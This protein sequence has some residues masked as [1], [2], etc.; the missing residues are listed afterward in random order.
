MSGDKATLAVDCH[1]H[2]YQFADL[3]RLLAAAMTNGEKARGR[4]E[5]PA[6]AIGGKAILPTL[7]LTEPKGRDSFAQILDMAVR[8]ERH[9]LPGW[10]LRPGG[11][12][13]SV[14]AEGDDGAALIISGQQV[15][16][17]DCLEILAIGCQPDIEDG[18]AL[19]A[20]LAAIHKNGAFPVFPWGVG[21]WLGR[22]GRLIDALV[23]EAEPGDLAL[24]DTVA[25]PAWW[26]EPRFAAARARGLMI[27]RGSDPLPLPGQVEKAGAFGN[28]MR[29]PF[30]AERPALS[31]LA[32][33]R[34]GSADIISFGQPD[35]CRAF[36]SAQLAL[37]LLRA[38]G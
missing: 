36:L 24:A 3:P 28:L 17:K 21:K 5:N 9:V 29:I 20:A 15:V 11:D 23:S 35:S 7:V 13:L 8:P 22:R 6:W 30:D 1:V 2:L 38:A 19:P 26:P 16:T 25:R 12:G 31:L 27:L 37:R 4:I 14:F 32:A 33:L 34:G 10:R 18:A